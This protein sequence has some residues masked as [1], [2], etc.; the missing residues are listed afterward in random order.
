MYKITHWVR[1]TGADKLEGLMEALWIKAECLEID[2]DVE[3][4]ANTEKCVT[5]RQLRRPTDHLRK[6]RSSMRQR[7]QVKL[8]MNL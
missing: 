6:K 8:M 5:Y 4:G 3:K 7:Y 2:G 1:R